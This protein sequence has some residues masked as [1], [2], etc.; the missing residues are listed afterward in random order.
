MGDDNYICYK[1][2]QLIEL[3][4]DGRYSCVHAFV[5]EVDYEWYGS[6]DGT[7][8]IIPT[9]VEP[10]VVLCN[11]DIDDETTYN[12][13]YHGCYGKK[14]CKSYKKIDYDELETE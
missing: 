10:P 5:E 12:G 7:K 13:R 11:K 1:G 14:G 4:D 8:Y 9:G 2:E 3:E 6:T